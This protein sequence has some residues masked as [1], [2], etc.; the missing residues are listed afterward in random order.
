MAAD[1]NFD[2]AGALID[3]LVRGGVEHA[4]LSPGSRSAPLTITATR[5]PGLRCWSQIDERSGSF[6]GLGLAKTSRKPVV[7]VCTSGTAT[8]NYH[9]AVVE[10][11]HARV[12]LIVLTADRPPELHDCG[13]GQT[14][15][16]VE[17]Y[18]GAVRWFAETPIPGPEN[19]FEPEA[20]L[21]ARDAIA[22]AASRPRGPV[23]L[24]VPFREPLTPSREWLERPVEPPVER[25]DR[26]ARPHFDV[27]ALEVDSN[28][29]T[30]L[31]ERLRRSQQGVI[32]CGPLD[33]GPET[34]AA[35]LE[36]TRSLGWPLL[37][38]A[39]SQLR[40]APGAPAAPL[41]T[42]FDLFL[43]DDAT[44]ARL[45]PDFVLRFGDSPT[46][47]AQRLWLERHPP[48]RYVLVDPDAVGH[49]PSRFAT[50]VLKI[51]PH[52]LCG[53]LREQLVCREARPSDWCSSFL[54]ADASANDTVSAILD[55]SDRLLEAR[56]VRELATAL[57]D[58][59]LLYVSNSMPARD[60]DVFLTVRPEPLRILCNRGANG[61]D[62]VTSSALGAAAA[63]LGPVVLLTGDLAFLHDAGGLLA[64]RRHGLRATIVVLDNGGGGIFSYL[65]VAEH[66][67]AVHFEE[68]FRTPHGL[69]LASVAN[70]YGA[71][72]VR[73][74]SWEHLRAGLKEALASQGVSVLVVPIDRDLNVAQHREIQAAVA[75]ALEGGSQP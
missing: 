27:S 8:T 19:A 37:A 75:A 45:A 54:A 13:A 29:L 48:E 46:S 7:L 61:I 72:P 3:E 68:Y 39:A 41:V 9:S 18:G 71:R 16:Q 66:H 2:F 1:Y 14:I 11:H 53:A 4:I 21:L 40:C 26:Q 57:P 49:D 10:A 35:I 17:L 67:E 69:D 24:N 55:G 12:P 59:A 52:S 36:L 32:I 6:F 58:D 22:K 15:D 5:H 33:E 50:D 28:T 70:A 43:R 64:A 23:H 20:R 65:P 47:K 56:V 51:T 73:V 34:T 30:E 42:S 25:D 74:E 31:V 63:D 62:G 44:R 60:V 38:D